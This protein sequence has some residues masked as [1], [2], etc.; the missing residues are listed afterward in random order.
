MTH[1]APLTVYKASAGSGKT[2]T[3]AL[4]YIKLLISDPMNYRYTLAVT[5]TNKATEEMK[6][7][8]LTELYGICNTLEDSD[9]YMGLL[10]AT[11]PRLG[12]DDI[13]ERARIAMHQILHHYHHFRVETID[14]FFQSILRNLARELGLPAN[15]QVGLNDNDVEAEAVDNIIE[16][17]DDDRDQLLGWI[18]DFV[19]EKVDKDLNWNVTQ[20]IKTFGQNIFKDF[21]KN[22]QQ[23]LARI[24][25]DATFFDDYTK[26]LRKAKSKADEAMKE[27]ADK[28]DAIMTTHGLSEKHISQGAKNAPGYFRRLREGTYAGTETDTTLPNSYVQKAIDDPQT[29]VKKADQGKPEAD[30]IVREVGAL[31]RE[32]EPL[33]QQMAVVKHSVELTLKHLNELRLLGRIEEEVRRINQDNGNFPLSSTQHLLSQL[34]D[35]QDSPFIYEKIGGQLRFIMIDEFQDTSTVQWENFKVLLDDCLAHNSGSLIVGDVKQ[36]IYRWRGGDWQLLQDLTPRADPRIEVKT[37]STNYRSRANVIRFNNAFFTTAAKTITDDLV[38][39]LTR[40]GASEPLLS[41]AR[42]LRQ[43]YAD[44]VQQVG[45]AHIADE[46]A[47]AG[48]VT[49]KLLPKDDYQERMLSE[50]RQCVELLLGQGIQPRDIAVLVR[51]KD[52]IQSLAEYFQ[53]HAVI[54]NGREQMVNMVSDEAFRL[55]ASLA[56]CTI[57]RAMYLLEHPDDRLLMATLAKAYHRILHPTDDDPTA[58]TRLF[59]GHDDLRPALPPLMIQEWDSLLATPLVDLAERLYQIFELSRLDGQSAY[60]CAFMDALADFTQHHIADIDELMNEWETTLSG[61]SISSDEVNGIRMLTIHKSKG[62]ESAHIIVP[63]CDWQ[64]EKAGETLWLETQGYAPYSQLPVVPV[65]LSARKMQQSIYAAQYQEEH[66]RNLVDNLNLIYVAF[67]RAK[68]NLFV[69]GQQTATE[70]SKKKTDDESVN[71][72]YPSR[73]IR[74]VLD[75]QGPDPGLPYDPLRST[76][77]P[78]GTPLPTVSMADLLPAGAAGKD[79]DGTQ[80]FVLGQLWVPAKEKEREEAESKSKA[81]A[82]DG[83]HK[84][85]EGEP[86]KQANIFKQPQE[87]LSFA[88]RNYTTKGTFVQSNESTR[89]ILTEEEG[90]ADLHRQQFIETGN[91]LHTLLA[92]IKDRSD[93]RRAIDNL[94][95][96]GVLYD[97]PMTRRQLTDLIEKRLQKPEVA[98]WF[99]GNWKVFNECSIL[100]YDDEEGRVSTKRPDRVIYDGQQMLVIDFKTG[101]ESDRH[102]V[103]VRTYMQLL[104]QM[105]YTQVSGYL[106]YIRPNKVVRIDELP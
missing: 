19:N 51:K 65:G 45:P 87:P 53:Q 25:S 49:V 66:I 42:A 57:I 97:K 32:T 62:L 11:Y 14:S 95:F 28:F 43:A 48:Q 15:M 38:A 31:L 41:R 59:V 83:G 6:T 77:G 29:L 33:R 55:D 86:A 1:S 46:E 30:I 106:W 18:M 13:R 102:H 105:G 99:D 20:Q 9:K 40:Y 71:E 79:E 4:E 85:Q 37:L 8:I 34:I 2:F 54:V 100:Y 68:C 24:M 78:E 52:H 50:V 70:G 35:E 69:F 36:S 26:K 93:I 82:G 5:F 58:D 3:L 56:V 44:V 89:Y 10:M 64:L 80:T 76:H 74:R 101:A 39:E 16:G 84:E 17:I 61:K 103:Q 63:Y 22:H 98:A 12:A 92:S 7:R 67:T 60:V 96:D 88:I 47:Q 73:L 75:Y 81:T 72:C 91:I 27:Q 21:Y 94:G 23:E 90:E 104:R